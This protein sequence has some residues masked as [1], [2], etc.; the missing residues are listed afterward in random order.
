MAA[1]PGQMT[2]IEITGPGGPEVL[3]PVIRDVPVPGPNQ[4]LIKVHAAGI[5]R[6]DCG[7]RKRGHAPAGAT[8]I[9]GLEVAG[10]VIAI[11]PGVTR[12]QSGALVCALVNGGGYAEYCLAEE[13]LTL[14]MPDRMDEFNAAAL[15]EA[16][17]TLWHNLFELCRLQPGEWL[18]VHGGA[19]GVGTLTIQIARH[20]GAFVIV[21][22]GSDEKCKVCK[23]LGAHTAVNYQSQDFVAAVKAATDGRGVNV[24]LDMVG[25]LY[26]E[27]NL[28]ALAPDG[29]ISHLTT[30]SVP[31]YE[32]DLGTM[33]QKRAMVTGS[34]LRPL[35]LARKAVIAEQLRTQVWPLLGQSVTPVIDSIFPLESAKAAHERIES[36]KHIGKILLDCRAPGG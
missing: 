33:M 4:V 34:M 25:G 17:F 12:W 30:A 32:V 13:R 23:E 8:D 14:P 1:A 16:L 10:R 11:G 35:P 27:R 20:F 3:R 7:Q 5:N 26:A 21:T 22:A 6:H 36:G 9:P 24:I 31:S 19:S 2:A 28:A 15:P 29:R 18:L